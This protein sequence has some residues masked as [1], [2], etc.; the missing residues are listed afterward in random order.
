MFAERA[1]RESTPPGAY[2]RGT[3]VTTRHVRY[4]S[5]HIAF[6]IPAGSLVDELG[7]AQRNPPAPA[8]ELVTAALDS[9]YGTKPL[10]EEVGRRV[11]V[12]VIVDDNTRPTPVHLIAPHIVNH[13]RDA[14][15]DRRDIRFL[16]AGGTHRPMTASELRQKLG[17]SIVDHYE[18]HNHRYEQP[19]ALVQLG[20][21][22]GG[23]PITANRI[24]CTAGFVIGVGNIVPH[25]Y[26]GW[27]GGAKIIQPGIGG[28]ATTAG[29]HLMITKFPDVQLGAVENSVRAEMEGVAQQVGL[30]FI[31]NTVLTHEQ[32]LYAVVAG[33]FRQAF[34][35]GVR[36]AESIY[37]R[38]I[39]ACAD[40]VIASAYPSDINL[41]QAAKALYAAE[42]MVRPNGIII[43][44]SPCVEGIGEHEEFAQ[45]LACDYTVI[46]NRIAENR[47]SDRVGAA[48]A[49]AVAQ[50]RN[51]AQVYLVS[52][53]IS[54]KQAA[55]MGL[56][57]FTG[58]QEAVDH[59]VTTKGSGATV[60]IAHEATEIVPV[61]SR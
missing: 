21:T 4:G 10:R 31:V 12:T 25:R 38:P 2:A 20:T 33:E 16:I 9:P 37:A 19:E 44:V 43:L 6:E 32:E 18:V 60:S 48:A 26:C 47:V 7:I 24:A 15:I 58:L 13:L 45:L 14:G 3:A 56:E 53:G 35:A 30:H 17:D 50:V 28:E 42:L 55:T 34:R 54:K 57:L 49:L 5:K 8:T 46:D 51:Q 11:P 1:G 29:T 59:A 23:I 39:T 22:A 41:W 61:P 40:I 52:D 36:A 27:S